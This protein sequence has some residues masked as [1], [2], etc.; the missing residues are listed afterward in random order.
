MIRTRQ[1]QPTQGKDSTQKDKAGPADLQHRG[2]GRSALSRAQSQWLVGVVAPPSTP[3]LPPWFP[4]F[5]LQLMKTVGRLPSQSTQSHRRAVG[6]WST[7]DLTSGMAANEA[8]PEKKR[9]AQ[10]AVPDLTSLTIHLLNTLPEEAEQ[11]ETERALH[12]M[13]DFLKD[14]VGGL[15]TH[16]AE[17]DSAFDGALAAT[18]TG[19]GGGH[20]N[21]PYALQAGGGGAGANVTKKVQ[22]Q[23]EALHTMTVQYMNLTG[24]VDKAEAKIAELDKIVAETAESAKRLEHDVKQLKM[25]FPI[26]SERIQYVNQQQEDFSK[27][28]MPKFA[29]LENDVSAINGVLQLDSQHFVSKVGA[30]NSG[31]LTSPLFVM[32][33][34]RLDNLEEEGMALKRK[35]RDWCGGC[36]NLFVKLARSRMA[37]TVGV[38]TIPSARSN[39]KTRFGEDE[40]DQEEDAI[41][42]GWSMG[43]EG[44]DLGKCLYFFHSCLNQMSTMEEMIKQVGEIM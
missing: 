13:H 34:Q 31:G 2:P 17:I 30:L 38:E 4:Q 40:E 42:L 37:Q 21:N 9:L 8:N 6:S 36:D 43:F 24:R 15:Q 10:Y 5:M 18:D 25:E 39:K 3:P 41:R 1:G 19:K 7:V 27:T 32:Y 16:F 28:V 11:S 33:D 35:V 22:E 29:P 26:I 20:G 12:K 23:E 14:L 44:S